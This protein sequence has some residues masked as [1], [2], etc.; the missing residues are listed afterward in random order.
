MILAGIVPMVDL[1]DVENMSHYLISYTF[2]HILSHF[3]AHVLNH[4]I[5]YALTVRIIHDYSAS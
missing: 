4:L 2:C 5:L 3:V 1:V